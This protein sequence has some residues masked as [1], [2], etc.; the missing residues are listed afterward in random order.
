VVQRLNR[1]WELQL[2][3]TPRPSKPS[4]IRQV[5][6]EAGPRANLVAQLEE[7]GA[8]EVVYTDFTELVYAAGKAQLITV[9]DHAT[10]LVPGWAVG[11][12]TSTA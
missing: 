7:I 4:G 6:I 5:L 2:A 11:P 1:P 9:V 8:F 12:R 10:K 3:R